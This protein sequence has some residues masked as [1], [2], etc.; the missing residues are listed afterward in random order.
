M[1]KKALMDIIVNK[2]IFNNVKKIESTS[3]REFKFCMC[4]TVAVD[5][6]MLSQKYIYVN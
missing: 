3:V 5:D 2:I 1:I 6:K 4:G